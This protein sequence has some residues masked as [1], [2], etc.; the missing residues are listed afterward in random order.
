MGLGGINNK[1]KKLL[2]ILVIGLLWC[3]VGVAEIR[4]IETKEIT[5]HN[6]KNYMISTICV[7]GYKFVSARIYRDTRVSMVQFF[8]ERDGKSLPTK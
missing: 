7:D 1:L 8:E 5:G 3:N 6:V 2:G 4:F